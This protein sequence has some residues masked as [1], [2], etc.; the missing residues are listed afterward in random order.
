MTSQFISF[1]RNQKNAE[2]RM[3]I[4][5]WNKKK[6]DWNFDRRSCNWT[7]LDLHLHLHWKHSFI[8]SE[9]MVQRKC[10]CEIGRVKMTS[11]ANW[12]HLKSANKQGQRSIGIYIFRFG[13]VKMHIANRINTHRLIKEWNEWGGERRRSRKTFKS[14]CNLQLM[15]QTISCYSHYKCINPQFVFLHHLLRFHSNLLIWAGMYW[16]ALK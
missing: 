8:E 4:L 5:L 14:L 10:F 3:K 9:Y 7:N 15:L 11:D 12:K 1:M 6:S 13:N 16:F 2:E